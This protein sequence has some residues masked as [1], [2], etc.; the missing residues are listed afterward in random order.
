MNSISILFAFAIV[1]ACSQAATIQEALTVD[2]IED[3]KVVLSETSFDVVNGDENAVPTPLD[4]RCTINACV[5]ICL[6][7]MSPPLTAWCSGSTCYCQ[8]G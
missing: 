5:N 4:T 3:G 8:K 1:F 6:S 7:I 2:E